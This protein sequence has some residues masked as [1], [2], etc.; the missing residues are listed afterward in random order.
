M[1]KN[2]VY[3]LHP[4]FA[5]EESSLANL[6]E[7]TG[8]TVEEWVR[9]VKK[10]GPP[11]E[12]ERIAWLK[13][14]HGITTNYAGWIAKRVDGGG[15]PASYDPDAM[16]EEMFAGK[17]AAL[18]PIYDHMLEWA[19][20]LGKD[21]RVSPCKTIV[22]FYRKHVF[23]Q[24]KPATNTRVDLGVALKGMKP[25]GK[26]LSTGGFE[27]GDRITHRIP[28]GS[29]EEIDKEVRKWLKQAYEMDV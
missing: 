23:A 2:S 10:S 8:R 16:V 7:R 13:S 28:V 9:I 18:R 20:G 26:L 25:A 22:P 29:V 14:A 27:K 4:G 12:Q 6:K 3:T 1:R 19:F 21:V 5:M 24:V 15:S 17:K 11:T